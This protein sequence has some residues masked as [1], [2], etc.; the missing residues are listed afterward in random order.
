MDTL[1]AT[2][3][4]S[5]RKSFQSRIHQKSLIKQVGSAIQLAQNGKLEAA[6]QILSGSVIKHVDGCSISGKQPHRDDWVTD[7]DLQK[8]IYWDTHELIVL[9]G[10]SPQHAQFPK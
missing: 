6:R 3:T 5:S 2:M 7:C 10:I 1:V 9:L 8:K 4:A